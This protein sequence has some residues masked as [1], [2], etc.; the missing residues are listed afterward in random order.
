MTND[1][2][3]LRIKVDSLKQFLLLVGS[4]THVSYSIAFYQNAEKYNN[5]TMKC[6]LG[7]ITFLGSP[8][9]KVN[10]CNMVFLHIL[11]GACYLP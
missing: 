11:P 10:C 4:L 2:E 7:L 6:I 3:K 8:K 9:T 5:I 1:K